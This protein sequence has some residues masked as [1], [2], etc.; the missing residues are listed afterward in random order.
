[1]Y[2]ARLNASWL[3]KLRWAAVVG[4]LITI[5]I[6][7][8]VLQIPLFLGPLLVV[9]AAT[10]VSNLLLQQWIAAHASISDT[11][12]GNR[13]FDLC[14]GLVSTMDLLSLTALLYATG[15]ATNPF[16]LFYFVNLA[17]SAILLPRNWVWGLN[18]LAIV[19]FAFLMY[20][21]YSVDL[22]SEGFNIHPARWT[23]IWSLP[24]IA[25]IIA[26][27]GSS[28]MTVY[29]LT[30]LTDSLRQHELELREAQ[31]R[32]AVNEKIEAL[33]T[34]AAGAAHELATP[35]STIAVVAREVEKA[36]EHHSCDHFDH[37]TVEDIHLIRRELDRC[38]KI[39]DRMS[40]DA[41]QTIAEAMQHV[42]WSRIRD[43]TLAG[44]HD[45]DRIDWRMEVKHAEETVQIPLVGLGQ[46]LR[47]LIQNGLDASS[48]RDHVDV[49]IAEA[50]PTTWTIAIRDRGE[51]MSRETAIRVGQPFFTT[52][53][54]GK[55]MGLGVFLADS[56]IRRLGG[57]MEIE[58][59]PGEGTR[60]TI[61]LPKRS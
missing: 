22:L 36:I 11:P 57:R 37:E 56:L 48:P 33:G 61:T 6:V 34:L 10:A 8:L 15:G 32:K 19:C 9:I 45:A 1:M 47:G 54:P 13:R 24:Q 52:K 41:G 38:R 20:D 40:V 35:L 59:E 27:A 51:G 58:S 43:E 26:F 25:L 30:R 55:G 39:L 46:A 42:P 5:A 49:Q 28:S 50:N 4:Q 60:I 44:L 14:M 18:L 23:G 17:L 31:R 16:F 7:G 21:H 12:E 3:L 53:P 2:R 29:F